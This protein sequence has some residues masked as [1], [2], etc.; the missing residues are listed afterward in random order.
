MNN[1]KVIIDIEEY[2]KFKSELKSKNEECLRL[3][4]A[5]KNYST[6]SSYTVGALGIICVGYKQAD[7]WAREALGEK[8]PL[9]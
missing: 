6:L 8:F 7:M 3:K 4:K 5:L 9:I 2:E 1:T